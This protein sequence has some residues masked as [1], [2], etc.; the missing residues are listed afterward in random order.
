MTFKKALGYF[1]ISSPFVGIYVYCAHLIGIGP[2]TLL[3][4]AACG[5]GAVMQIGANLITNN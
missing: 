1:L 2:I 4:A 5:V 3:A